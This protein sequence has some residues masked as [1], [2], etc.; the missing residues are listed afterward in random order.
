MTTQLDFA[1][2]GKTQFEASLRASHIALGGI[3]RFINLHLEV[4][5]EL[6]N[7]NTQTLKALAEVKDVQGLVA[8]QQ[9]LAQPVMDKVLSIA[10]SAYDV[11][12]STATEASQLVEEQVAEFNKQLVTTLD[13]AAKSAPA[14]SEIVV[15]AVKT[16][17][18]TAASAYETLSKTAKKV[19]SDFA[20][21][22]VAAAE[23]SA[24]AASTVA[25]RAKKASGA[26]AA[27]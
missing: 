9:Q 27:T 4:S 20:E 12:A 5:R 18:A 8:L 24:K 14:G 21:A 26:S 2:L 11:A 19:G 3:E 23:T 13:R 17:V 10:R 6:L 22:S 25:A 7:D 1:Q 16:A 15:S